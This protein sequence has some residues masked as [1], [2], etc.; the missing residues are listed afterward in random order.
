MTVEAYRERTCRKCGGGG[1]QRRGDMSTD[2][3]TCHGE[4]YVVIPL[5]AG[6]A[7]CGH[8]WAAHH[9]RQLYP[10]LEWYEAPC[11]GGI[12]DCSQFEETL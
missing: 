4:G 3:P 2:C 6:C 9:R 5:H 8:T 7:A 1:E 11:M 12:C 10:T